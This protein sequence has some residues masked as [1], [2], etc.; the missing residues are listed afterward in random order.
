MG[1]CVLKLAQVGRLWLRQICPL[2][3]TLGQAIRRRELIMSEHAV[4]IRFEYGSTDLDPVHELEDTLTEV[5]ESQGV[6][7]YDGHEIAV[8]G[9]DGTLYMYGPDADRLFSAV[10]ERLLATSVLKNA[11]A[12]LRYG[13]PED[14]VYEVEVN[15]GA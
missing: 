13:P 8:D 12:T 11:I 1:R 15:F 10:K 7:E 6:G 5:I 2:A 4:I 14:G 3:R 9:S